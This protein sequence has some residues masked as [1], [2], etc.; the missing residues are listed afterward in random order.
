M[1]EISNIIAGF[2]RG[3]CYSQHLDRIVQREGIKQLAG[4]ETKTILPARIMGGLEVKSAIVSCLFILFGGVVA[5][6]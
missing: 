1:K 3:L 5:Y 4:H 6:I 2:S